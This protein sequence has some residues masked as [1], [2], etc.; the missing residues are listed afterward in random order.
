MK[1]V[2]LPFLVGLG[3]MSMNALADHQ[4]VPG[5]FIV[6]IKPGQKSNLLKSLAKNG[7]SLKRDLKLA[8][9]DF[10]L[11]KGSNTKSLKS[12]SEIIYFEPNYI[13]KAIG[14]NEHLGDD[15]K[16]GALWG[17]LNTGSNEP[18]KD[19]TTYNPTP[20]VQG[21]DVNAIK[22]WDITKGS[23]AVTIA[24]ID[25]GIDYNHEDLKN[26]M[27]VNPKEIAGNNKDDDNNGY[28]DDVYGYNFAAKNSN[29]MDGNGH[30]THCAGT[31][32][33]EHN[34]V[35]VAGVMS[36]VKMMA[37][38]FLSDEGSGTSAD[39]IEAI[40]YATK[41]DVDLMSNSWGGGGFSQTLYDS[42]DAAKKKGILFIAAAGN[43]ATNN[44]QSPHYPSNY[45]VD[46]VI[47]VAAH[48]INDSLASFSCFG[49]RTVHIAAPGKNIMSSTPNNTYSVYSGTS[50][51]TPHV[52]GVL[53][54][55]L[56][57]EGRLPV[58]EVRER[59]MATSI[60]VG[61]YRR[62]TLSGG[63]IDAY[64]LLTDT[65]PARATPPENWQVQNLSEIF[66][67]AH[68][69][70]VNTKLTKTYSFPN[71]KHIRVII[72]KFS[73]EKGYDFVS[74]KSASGEVIEKLDGEGQNYTTDYVDGDSVTIEFSSDASQNA[75]GV[76]ISKVEVVY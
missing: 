52:S 44:D 28:V 19:G 63:R 37:V 23:K 71:A 33:A 4:A 64:N 47:S 8:F 72:D 16:F 74:V 25:T 41:M 17:L 13:L 5:E 20:G 26:N 49:R 31:I 34:S 58:L 35:G 45:E 54:L 55:L 75:W 50:M 12:I 61:S 10:I 62:T 7:F 46:N 65:R 24:V 70:A 67:S 56:A 3:L 53:G 30:G 15:A 48:A 60:P 6:K 76:K 2:C 14:H 22:A 39:A 1:R 57:K 9:G 29:P 42:I 69:Y 40:N 27:W 51:A 18:S 32:G 68:P 36:E 38:K 66:E 43:S 21:A 73:T 59:V 11:V